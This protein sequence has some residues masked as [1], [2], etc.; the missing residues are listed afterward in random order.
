MTQAEVFSLLR[1]AVIEL[2]KTVG[3]AICESSE[4]ILRFASKT[5]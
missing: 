5:I 2:L 3:G 4:G 1:E